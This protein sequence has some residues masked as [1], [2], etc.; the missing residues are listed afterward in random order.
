MKRSP[1]L[2]LF[3]ACFG[4][5]LLIRVFVGLPIQTIYDVLEGLGQ[6][7]VLFLISGLFH[8]RLAGVRKHWNN[9]ADAHVANY[10]VA[11]VSSLLF[12]TV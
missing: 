6:S 3:F 7:L 12:A 9:L 11:E 10:C 5:S 4:T 2:E 8:E 1:Y